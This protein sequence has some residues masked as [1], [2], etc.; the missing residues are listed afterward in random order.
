MHDTINDEMLANAS[1]SRSKCL[2]Q[3]PVDT[4][5][6]HVKQYDGL[7]PNAHVGIAKQLHK[8]LLNPVKSLRIIC[9]LRNEQ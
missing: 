7:V 4:I 3:L 8:Q 6:Q 2:K 9:N 1:N 5:I